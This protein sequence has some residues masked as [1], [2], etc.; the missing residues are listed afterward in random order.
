M[1]L[2]FFRVRIILEVCGSGPFYRNRNFMV[3]RLSKQVVFV[4]DV[5]IISRVFVVGIIGYSSQ[6]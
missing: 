4:V 6:S 5:A 1:D 2:S 3:A